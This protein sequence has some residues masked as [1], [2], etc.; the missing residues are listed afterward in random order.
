MIKKVSICKNNLNHIPNCEDNKFYQQGWVC[1][2]CGGV[3]NP[4]QSYCPRCTPPMRLDV[5]FDTGTI[6]PNIN[7][8]IS[9]DIE[10]K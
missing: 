10:E 9:V 1:P 5:N 3:Y 8:S 7:Q 4:S 6:I 2:K